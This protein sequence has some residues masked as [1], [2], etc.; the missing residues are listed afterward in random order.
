MAAI[1]GVARWPDARPTVGGSHAPSAWL[2]MVAGP[3]RWAQQKRPL[4]FEITTPSTNR[5]RRAVADQAGLSRYQKH[6]ANATGGK[7]LD[8]IAGFILDVGKGNHGTF[9]F[10]SRASGDARVS[11]FVPSVF[12]SGEWTSASD[13]F[14][15]EF[16]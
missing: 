4:S 2:A 1:V 14:A 6:G 12:E 15:I 11:A 8:V 7:A 5:S 10:W 16:G 13:F 9:A 3:A